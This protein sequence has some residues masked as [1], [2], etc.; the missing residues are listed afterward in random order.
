[1]WRSFPS[2]RPAETVVL[3]V[4]VILAG[5]GGAGKGEPSTQVVQGAGFRFA[6]PAAWTLERGRESVAAVGEDPDRVEVRTFRLVKP[7]RPQLFDAAARELDAVVARIADQ[8][9]GRVTSR[10]TIRVSGRRARTYRIDYGDRTQ[11][12]TF[13]LKGMLEYQLLCRRSAN[14][15]EEACRRLVRSFTLV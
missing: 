12:L 8:L 15:D 5:C 14:G 2:H 10:D 9:S 1:M 4:I 6:A 13:V 11:E 7:Y 3:V